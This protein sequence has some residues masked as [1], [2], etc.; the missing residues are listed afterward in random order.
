MTRYARDRRVY[1]IEEPIY[2]ESEAPTVTIE[3]Q[4]NVFV[5]VPQVPAHYS[6]VQRVAAQ[7]LVVD[8]LIASE[9][10]TDF[11]LWYY[12]PM[13]L[14][15]S[16][17]LTPLATVYDCMD[18][19]SAFKNA[20][21]ALPL[22]ERAL[23]RR[24]DVVFTGGRSL[25]EAKQTQHGNIH[26]IPSSVDVTHF[27]TARTHLPDPAD[28]RDI[29]RPRL[30]FFGVLDERLDVS[31]L[32]GLADARPDW[33]FIMIGPIVKIDPEDL[34]A[35]P[36]IHYLGSKRYQELPAYIGGWDV[37]LLLFARNESTRFI[38]PTKTPEYLAAGAPVVST[39]ITDV[40]HPYA[41]KNL[42]HIA[43]SVPD[44][45][46]A[47]ERVLSQPRDSMRARADQ[48]LRTMSWDRTWAQTA[49]LL[50]KALGSRRAR[51]LSDTLPIGREGTQSCST[52]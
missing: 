29:P 45:V 41:D 40:V 14:Q 48:F 46:S 18:E 23:M 39:S 49:T 2:G 12:T 31:L 51:E 5:V 13:A 3:C 10:L 44:F 4:H 22:F 25:F 24:A 52:T 30:G 20:S 37:A 50:E 42:V 1:F 35:R 47:C 17:H 36:N 33:Q 27:A 34:P 38:S 8:R 11:V 43:D 19:L 7:R 9:R 28:Q 6:S 16:E 26:A 21:S 15:F 32:A